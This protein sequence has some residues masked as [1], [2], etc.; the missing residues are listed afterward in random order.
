MARRC[1]SVVW[2]PHLPSAASM[3]S[4]MRSQ[5]SGSRTVL[6]TGPAGSPPM[7]W[8]P[9]TA[10]LPDPEDFLDR[11][12]LDEL[13]YVLLELEAFWGR[14]GVEVVAELEG[15]DGGVGVARLVQAPFLAHAPG[16][17]AQDGVGHAGEVAQGLV[18][19]LAA[20]QVHP[21]PRLRGQPFFGG[22]QYFRFP[23]RT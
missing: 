14:H 23:P 18:A 3:A 11:R 17:R 19:V 9:D 8:G 1:S 10:A 16:Y 6:S 20:D 15:G 21:G 5:S 4:A 12:T 13:L 22:E 2:K 7:S